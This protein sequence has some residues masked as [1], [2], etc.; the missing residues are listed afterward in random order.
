MFWKKMA[1]IPLLF[2]ASCGG[3]NNSNNT[4]EPVD[5]LAGVTVPT[6]YTFISKFDA[7]KSS[8]SYS[9]QTLRNV[10]HKE[11]GTYMKGLTAKIDSGDFQPVVGDTLEALNFYYEFDS[12]TGGTN[13]LTFTATPGLKQLSFGEISTLKNIKE[14]IAGNDLVGQH[15]D[16]T[17]EFKGWDDTGVTG[18]AGS[19][20][21]P[22]DLIISF[23]TKLDELAANRVAGNPELDPDG[24]VISAVQV[25]S[26]GLNLEQLTSKFMLGALGYSQAI[27]DYLDDDLADKGLNSN[28]V[29]QDGGTASYTTLEH[30][31]DEA[32]GYYGA[33]RDY[34]NFT[35]AA[36][37][38]SGGN[39]FDT[40]ADGK[41]DLTSEYNFTLAIYANKRDL[42]SHVD[43]PT[44]FSKAIF[45]A[46][47]TGRA[48]ITAA[49]G[50]L[51][52]DELAEVKKQRTII[53]NNWEKVLAA[54]TI[55]YLNAVI[56]D[57]AAFGT[58]G[59][60]FV[61]HAGHWSEMKGF[62]LCFQFS[63]KK[64]ISEANFELI[65]EKMG[66]Q[67]VLATA[68]ATAIAA[69]KIELLAIRDILQDT[70]DF[71]DKNMGDDDGLNGWK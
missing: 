44:N 18:V 16:W 22:E 1:L 13:L 55:H 5:V 37:S 42:G 40:D 68:G 71:D 28:N 64:L 65:H 21:T 3:S 53:A 61:G 30:A 7:T 33:S 51:S 70:Y 54:N 32:F 15:K 39:F 67:P 26:N 20:A 31:W 41:V 58:A 35:D 4:D 59:Y 63:S 24:A 50:N 38:A 36:L 12:T 8:V 10:L 62:A 57:M 47:L 9:G 48:V 25:T 49:D 2:I 69:Y 27:D 17:T 60:S 6:T 43:A 45:D 46:F 56:V 52:V 14:K 29:A 34:E 66:V 11:L 19:V 23:F